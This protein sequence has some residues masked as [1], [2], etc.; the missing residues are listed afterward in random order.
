VPA[1]GYREKISCYRESRR[2]PAENRLWGGKKKFSVKGTKSER[3]HHKGNLMLLATAQRKKKK[4]KGERG[5]LH[6]L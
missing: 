6:W 5:K 4:K 3:K 1:N 2:Q